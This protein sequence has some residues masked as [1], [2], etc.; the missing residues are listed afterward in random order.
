ML[1]DHLQ[2][3]NH[4]NIHC[5]SDYCYRKTTK[6][7]KTCRMEFGTQMQPGNQLRDDPAIVF[8][9]NKCMRLEMPRDHPMLVQHSKHLTQGWRANSDI[10]III[11][12][13][14][15]SN[16]ALH[17]I[18]AT[19]K[20]VSG[21]ACKGNQPTCAMADLFSDLVHSAD[22]NSMAKSVCTKL[23]MNTVKRYISTA[24]ACYEL[25]ALPLYRCSR[26][27]QYLSMTGSRVLEWT[28]KTATKNTALDKYLARENDKPIS[29]YSYICSLGKV[30]AVGGNVQATWPLTVEYARTMLLLRWPSWRKIA[31]IVDVDPPNWLEKFQQF[32]DSDQC[33]SF[34]KA[35]VERTKKDH[36]S[37][38]NGDEED[39]D[40]CSNSQQPEWMELL[41]PN[42]IYD[43]F[44]DDF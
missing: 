32:L 17:E 44:V 35:E 23:L 15:P 21:Y 9:K 29:W 33:P 10:S 16:P 27:F 5:C 11:S 14:K 12:K 25:S 38:F 1:E 3:T 37:D 8:D 31:D 30:P 24:E 6:G 34:V 20:Y 13:S 43:D 40:N 18:I 4:I 7:V 42:T 41:Q 39:D 26:T 36:P 28:G 2:L 19:E 22:D